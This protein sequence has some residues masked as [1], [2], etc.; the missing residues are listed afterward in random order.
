MSNVPLVEHPTR[1]LPLHGHFSDAQIVE[2][3][4]WVSLENCR[5]RF[6][7]WLGLQSRGFSD[8]CQVP[9]SM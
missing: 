8:A 4:A 9:S 6:N 5:S 7:A 2:L 3:A 1:L